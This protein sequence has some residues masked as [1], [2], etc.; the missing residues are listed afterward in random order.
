M[1]LYVKDGIV[2]DIE[3]RDINL[4]DYYHIDLLKNFYSVEPD[5]NIAIGDKFNIEEENHGA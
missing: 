5:I 1:Y 4:A 3:R 2:V